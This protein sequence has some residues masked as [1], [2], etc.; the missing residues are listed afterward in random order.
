[1][2]T[3]PGRRTTRPR[4]GRSLRL[5]PA[6]NSEESWSVSQ[7]ATDPHSPTQPPFQD[8]DRA[9][10][11]A[12]STRWRVHRRYPGEWRPIACQQQYVTSTQIQQNGRVK[13]SAQWNM[14]YSGVT[15]G[16]HHAGNLNG[17]CEQNTVLP[18]RAW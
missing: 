2:T 12:R 7:G 15:G 9:R 3:I 4:G 14:V 6:T 5:L 8:R 18:G 11:S 13:S 17:Q 16:D 10:T 1:M